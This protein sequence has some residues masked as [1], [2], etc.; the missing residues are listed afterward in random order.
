MCYFMWMHFEDQKALTQSCSLILI[1]P[2]AAAVL[3]I[4]NPL[5][6][7]HWLTSSEKDGGS[8]LWL[9]NVSLSSVAKVC[10][11]KISAY[12]SISPRVSRVRTHISAWSYSLLMLFENYPNATP[13][14]L[15][16]KSAHKTLL[17]RSL[18]R[19][20]DKEFAIADMSFYWGRVLGVVNSPNV[21]PVRS[22]CVKT[23][24]YEG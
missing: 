24:A 6:A 9:G 16:R 4:G 14:L 21:S 11:L 3:L 13:R 8:T 12:R 20:G 1:V 2:A 15:K 22:V 18:G 7:S 19:G 23:F 5:D 17:E 10:N